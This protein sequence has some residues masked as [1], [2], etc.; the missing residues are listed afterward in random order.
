MPSIDFLVWMNSYPNSSL[1]IVT[2]L[3]I[4][5]TLQCSLLWKMVSSSWY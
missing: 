5:I 3:L 4:S 1:Y 2:Q